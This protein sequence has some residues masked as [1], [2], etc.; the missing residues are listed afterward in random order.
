MYNV[1]YRL[2]HMSTVRSAQCTVRVHSACA[3]YGV[4]DCGTNPCSIRTT[5]TCRLSCSLP[6]LRSGFAILAAVAVVA[7]V[8]A[9]N[10]ISTETQFRA[11]SSRADNVDV[12]VLCTVCV[13]CAMY[14]VL[15]TVYN[16][17][18]YYC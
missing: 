13:L 5:N 16:V 11:L 7:A 12:K 8:T 15:C 14:F 9:T 1:L 3:M 18:V 17:Q 6:L 4:N 10:D 2:S